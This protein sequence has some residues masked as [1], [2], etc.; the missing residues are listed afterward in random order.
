[1][2]MMVFPFGVD[3]A[4]QTITV[5]PL[6]IDLDVKKRD[7]RSE[8]I[9]I[10]NHLD[11]QVEL[12]PTVNEVKM[13]DGGVIADFVSPSGAD[14]TQTITNWLTFPR[15]AITIDKN[16]A[17]EFPLGIKIHPDAKPGVYHAFIGFGTQ[18]G[19]EAAKQVR[20]GQAPGVVL[21][22]SIEQDRSEYL[23][24]G[25]FM[26]DRFVYSD[27]NNAISYTLKNPGEA[28]VVPTGEII[29]YNT[30]GNE[31]AAVPVNPEGVQ[32]APRQESTFTTSVPIG[33]LL[34]KYKAMLTVEYGSKQ[35]AAVYD[36]V[37]FNVIHWQKL[38][39]MFG[40]LLLFAII[41][42]LWL[43]K[44]SKVVIDEADVDDVILSVNVGVSP[45][46]EHD[47]DLRKK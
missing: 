12:F 24:L 10:T 33:D 46:K 4:R 21:T 35:T 26:I 27:E 40:G 39:M 28:E 29:I 43:H 22:L 19:P 42:T 36:T 47:I 1:M 16:D 7:I 41:I 38:L 25:R 8:M 13:E 6:V 34:G 20:R 23:R 37:F 31:V 44:R 14:G 45:E 32:L 18:N 2:S 11:R 5:A 3:A 15:T 30:K 17:K 9:T